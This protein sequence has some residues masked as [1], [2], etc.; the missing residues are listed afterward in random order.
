MLSAGFL[1]QLFVGISL[2]QCLFILVQLYIYKRKEYFH[3]FLYIVSISVF[4]YNNL[5]QEIGFTKLYLFHPDL[6]ALLNKPLNLFGFWMYIHFGKNFIEVKHLLKIKKQVFVLEI[7]FVAAVAFFLL[8]ILLNLSEHLQSSI[9]LPLAFI[10]FLQSIFIFAK[11]Y[12]QKDPLNNFLLAG[13]LLIALGGVAGPIISLFLP[14]MGLGNP[15]VFYG[16]EIAVLMEL[17][18]LNTGLIYKTIFIEKKVNIA[19]KQLID[20]LQKNELLQSKINA[21]DRQIAEVQLAALSAQMNPHFI[22]NCMNSIQKYV[23]KKEKDKAMEFLQHFSELMRSVLDNSTKTKLGLDEEIYMLEKYILLEQ[24]RLNNKFSFT[25]L[26]EPGMQTDFY[27]V[28]GMIIQPYV[29]NAIWHGIMNMPEDAAGKLEL[30]FQ[31]EG[32][33]IKCIVQDNG[34]GRKKAAELEKQKSPGHKS[35]GMAIAQKRMELLQKEQNPLP[36]IKITDLFTAGGEA[37]GTHVTIYLPTE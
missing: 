5:E 1:H 29:E 8:A 33:F 13:G 32:S 10:L 17:L 20:E 16:L 18:L 36:Q 27:E 34:V 12:L 19:Q 35:Y 15:L 24:Q 23:L 2:F 22:F 31:K 7:C 3:Y 25:I 14:K 30:T 4:L 11:L 21:A 6:S 37:A 26:I 9:F 28:P